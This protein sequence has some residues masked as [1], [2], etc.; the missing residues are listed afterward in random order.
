MGNC[1]Y[2]D[3]ARCAETPAGWG[4][5]QYPMSETVP[6][7][8]LLRAA[9]RPREVHRGEGHGRTREI[10]IRVALGASRPRVITGIF[11]MPLIQ[12]TSGV[13]A[14]VV[15]LCTLIVIGESGPL[16]WKDWGNLALYGVGMF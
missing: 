8:G 3:T 16:P 11:R 6:P 9:L 2:P 10:G 13:A 7:R 4:L 15:L 1:S 12:M 5:P 14:G